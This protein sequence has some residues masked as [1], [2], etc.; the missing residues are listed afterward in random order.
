MSVVFTTKIDKNDDFSKN[1]GLCPS[2]FDQK[3]SIFAKKKR[4][5]VC[6]VNFKNCHDGMGMGYGVWG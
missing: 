1:E 2:C 6:R 3:R 5:H 4:G